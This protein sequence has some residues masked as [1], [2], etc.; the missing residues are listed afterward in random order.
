MA[1]CSV[2]IPLGSSAVPQPQLWKGNMISFPQSTQSFSCQLPIQ[3]LKLKTV[4]LLDLCL[5]HSSLW[6]SR[7]VWEARVQLLR[8]LLLSGLLLFLSSRLCY[9][10]NTVQ[11]PPLSAGFLPHVPLIAVP[12]G[13]QICAL[14]KVL[15]SRTLRSWALTPTSSSL[16]YSTALDFPHIP[17]YEPFSALQVFSVSVI[18]LTS[19][20]FLTGL[21]YPPVD[22][23][24]LRE[25]QPQAHL[26]LLCLVRRSAQDAAVTLGAGLCWGF[27]P[28]L[29]ASLIHMLTFLFPVSLPHG[30]TGLFKFVPAVFTLRM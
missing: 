30:G 27:W 14:S 17:L 15:S 5:Q 18:V 25:Q 11:Q 1:N 19:H 13:C 8:D 7:C 16:A 26:G 10:A 12:D 4:F 20:C 9:C 29:S 24:A 28:E 21:L 2:S 6:L 23:T 3:S 22:L